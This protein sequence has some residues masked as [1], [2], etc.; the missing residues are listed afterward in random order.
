M[1]WK[2][3][4]ISEQAK[5]AIYR[6]KDA[7]ALFSKGEPH[8]RGAMYLA[9]YAIECKIKAKAME[10]HRCSTLAALRKK[11]DLEHESVYSHGLEALVTDLLPKGTRLRLFTGEARLAFTSQVNTWS[12]EW[13]Y[14][15]KSPGVPKAQ[16]F[17]EAIGEV[18]DWL[19][20][21]A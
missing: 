20:N 15:P 13:R 8:A 6:R 5:A 2:H 12:P 3:Q 4:G 7:R 14:D 18:W 1:V 21:N 16:K 19:E 11:L 10:R 9:G 17:L